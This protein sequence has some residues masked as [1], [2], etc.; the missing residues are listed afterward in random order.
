MAAATPPAT[1]PVAAPRERGAWP[2]RRL[3]VAAAVVVATGLVAAGLFVGGDDAETAAGG[4]R[5]APEFDLKDVREGQPA[6]TLPTG[7]PVA[8]FFFASWCI[9]CREEMPIVQDLFENQDEVAI[10]GVNHLDHVADA[11]E[12][13][14]EYGATF[15]AAHDPG[16]DVA[17][18]YRLRTVPAT[19]FIGEDGRIDEVAYGG[20]DRSEFDEHVDGLTLQGS[21]G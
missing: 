21:R 8:L 7:K 1:P 16:G 15:P 9:P 11:R 18:K 17:L 4:N 10:V 14:S 12:F 2:V 3:V 6:V 13:M 19:V 20:L 5:V